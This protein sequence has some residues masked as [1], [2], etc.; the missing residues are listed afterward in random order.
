M[1]ISLTQ[2]INYITWERMFNCMAMKLSSTLIYIGS[3]V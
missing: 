1:C 2:S 3:T